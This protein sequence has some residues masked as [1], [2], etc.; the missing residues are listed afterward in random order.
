MEC[1]EAG[2]THREWALTQSRPE[3]HLGHQSKQRASCRGALG[4]GLLR[5]CWTPQGSGL[6]LS[7]WG[8]LTSH[9]AL[10]GG[11]LALPLHV[12]LEKTDPKSPSWM[13]AE[14]VPETD[15][16][17]PVG[18]FPL[19]LSVGPRPLQPPF[20]QRQV[21]SSPQPPAGD[22][23]G[24]APGATRFSFAPSPQL[25]LPMS[26]HQALAM[27]RAPLH[28][29]AGNLESDLDHLIPLRLDFLIW[30]M[31]NINPCV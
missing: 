3:A 18:L 22:G 7:V 30:K 24:W 19:F 20:N 6:P 14:P 25:C 17:L 23:G 29:R 21:N 4:P 13:E 8:H 2:V 1:R 5:S 31:D 27:P 15:P 12:T 9:L 28:V 16:W 11:I 26:A 10:L